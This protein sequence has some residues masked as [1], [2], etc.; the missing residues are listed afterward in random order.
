MR[1]WSERV[2]LAAISFNERRDA[3]KDMVVTYRKANRAGPQDG[4]MGNA[5][6][7]A[8]GS[9]PIEFTLVPT[10]GLDLLHRQPSDKRL[11]G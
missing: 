8:M 3:R 5:V 7:V 4:P 9:C 2:D 1:S 6:G 11:A 10:A